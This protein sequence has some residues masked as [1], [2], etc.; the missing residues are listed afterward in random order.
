MDLRRDGK[1]FSREYWN[2]KG[3]RGLKHNLP[4]GGQGT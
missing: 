3:R 4:S 1:E 2:K